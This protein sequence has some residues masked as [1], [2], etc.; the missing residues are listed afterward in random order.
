MIGFTLLRYGD[1]WKVSSQVSNLAGT[2][3]LGAA[4]PMTP[5]EYYRQTLPE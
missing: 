1:D 2:S 5:D 4:L 3:L